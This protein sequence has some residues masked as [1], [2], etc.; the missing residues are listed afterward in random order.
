MKQGGVTIPIFHCVFNNGSITHYAHEFENALYEAIPNLYAVCVAQRAR[1][2]FRHV[3]AGFFIKTSFKHDEE[4]FHDACKASIKTMKEVE[5][6]IDGEFSL[7]PALM[8]IKGPHP[9]TEEELLSIIFQQYFKHHE[10]G[11][12]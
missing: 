6:I 9:L 10:M 4:G 11:R 7:L 2:G 12:A 8:T 5:S 1:D 3:I